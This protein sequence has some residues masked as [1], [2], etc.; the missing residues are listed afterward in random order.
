M[1]P[2]R[3]LTKQAQADP[4]FVSAHPVTM[5]VELDFFREILELARE[6]ESMVVHDFAYAD[7]C[8]DG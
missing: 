6:Y 8:F 4:D 2:P 7:L 3:C 5:C 1:M